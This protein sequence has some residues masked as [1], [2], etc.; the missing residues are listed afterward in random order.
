MLYPHPWTK[1]VLSLP[2]SIT[3]SCPFAAEGIDPSSGCSD[4]GKTALLFPNTDLF[5][6]ERFRE[7]ILSP[8]L[9]HQRNIPVPWAVLGGRLQYLLWFF[10]ANNPQRHSL[11]TVPSGLTT[12]IELSDRVAKRSRKSTEGKWCFIS[13]PIPSWESD[14]SL[15]E[16][17]L[18]SLLC[19]QICL[20]SK[21]IRNIF[22]TCLLIILLSLARDVRDITHQG[23]KIKR[24][25]SLMLITWKSIYF[26]TCGRCCGSSLSFLFLCRFWRTWKTDI[27][28]SKWL[29]S[30]TGSNYASIPV[31]LFQWLH[32]LYL[33]MW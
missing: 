16:V 6:S 28:S 7:N 10:W 13:S 21:L 1:A 30:Q 8:L 18:S 27:T 32:W 14:S 17:S 5:I 26:C 25:H 33:T 20:W 15:N 12:Y 23:I 2:S 4:T 24:H 11:L 3:P 9:C 31:H 22:F 29:G 19:V